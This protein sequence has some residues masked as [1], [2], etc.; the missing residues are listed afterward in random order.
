M[1]YQNL[2]GYNFASLSVLLSQPDILDVRFEPK[3]Q[4]W[5]KLN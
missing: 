5:Q 1:F 2:V 4:D 3:N